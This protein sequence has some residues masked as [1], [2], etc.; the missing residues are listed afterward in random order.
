[1]A[2]RSRIASPLTD[3]RTSHERPVSLSVFN[4]PTATYMWPGF[5]AASQMS[6]PPVIYVNYDNRDAMRS[7]STNSALS[8]H[9]SPVISCVHRFNCQR[10]RSPIFV[11]SPVLTHRDRSTTNMIPRKRRSTS[12]DERYVGHEFPVATVAD[13]IMHS[14]YSVSPVRNTSSRNTSSRSIM[15]SMRYIGPCSS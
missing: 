14:C 11:S 10:G 5:Q 4:S 2:V 13:L 8:R 6:H 9:D 1:M 7:A 12:P 3:P 15:E